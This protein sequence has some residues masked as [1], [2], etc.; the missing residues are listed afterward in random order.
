MLVTLL[1]LKRETHLSLFLVLFDMDTMKI[2]FFSAESAECWT[3]LDISLI[4]ISNNMV[5]VVI[6]ILVFDFFCLFP[7]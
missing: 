3:E 1:S 2:L 6:V 5:I 4:R 7:L